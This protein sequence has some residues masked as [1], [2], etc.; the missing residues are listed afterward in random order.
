M[1]SVVPDNMVGKVMALVN[2]LVMALTPLAMILGGILAQFFPIRTIFMVCFIA[3]LFVFI[4]IF[5]HAISA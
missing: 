2:T 1:P 5:F 3:S 4:S